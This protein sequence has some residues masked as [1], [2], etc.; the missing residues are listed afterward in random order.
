[1]MKWLKQN[2]YDFSYKTMANALKFGDIKIVKWLIE[3]NCQ[4]DWDPKFYEAVENNHFELV[5]WLH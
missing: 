1:M 2:N 4:F 5:K 3:N